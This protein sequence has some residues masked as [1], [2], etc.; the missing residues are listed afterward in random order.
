MLRDALADFTAPTR[1]RR[2]RRAGLFF[3]LAL[4]LLF[5][6]ISLVGQIS[7][8]LGRHPNLQVS[9]ALKLWIQNVEGPVNL[10]EKV[11]REV[12]GT[13]CSMSL[14]KDKGDVHNGRDLITDLD[15]VFSPFILARSPVHSPL[16]SCFLSL[17]IW[18]LVM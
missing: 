17:T 13:F 3:S 4:L 2:L 12:G 11:G 5:G 8:S 6:G 14:L 15:G 7:E 1:A 18:K 9:L 16:L 10:E